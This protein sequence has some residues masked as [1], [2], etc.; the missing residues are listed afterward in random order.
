[1]SDNT[2]N[3]SPP[4]LDLLCQELR[5]VVEWDQVATNLKVPYVEIASITTRYHGVQ[6]CKMHALQRWLEQ[7]NTVHS[8][9]VVANAVKHI[10][11]AVAM[12][13]ERNYAL[14]LD[15]ESNQSAL[16]GSNETNQRRGYYSR[17][18]NNVPWLLMICLSHLVI[19][20]VIITLIVLF[21]YLIFK[22]STIN[23]MTTTGAPMY[24]SA[25]STLVTSSLM[26]YSL[27]PTP[28]PTPGN[29]N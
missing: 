3:L 4:T 14:V 27:S 23:P 25:S 2:S 6:Q 8:W 19:L 24:S 5:D 29:A 12:R 20:V 21:T 9:R 13:I 18:R 22:I 16:Q 1:M 10:N 7:V 15:E 26:T 17:A 28:S 11:P